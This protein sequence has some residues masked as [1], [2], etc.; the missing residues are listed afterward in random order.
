MSTRE[1]ILA[2][3]A[4]LFAQK[5]AQNTS[6]REIAAAVGVTKTAVLYHFTTKAEILATLLTPMLEDMEATLDAVERAA[7]ERDREWHVAV[8]MLDVYMAHRRV[9]GL[10]VQNLSVLAQAPVY[11]RW[12]AAMFRAN[13]LVTGD[14]STLAERVRATQA[15]ALL[16][17]PVIVIGDAPDEELRHLILDGLRRLLGVSMPDP[18][19]RT[20]PPSGEPAGRRLPRPRVHPRGGRPLSM[21]PEMIA[22]ARR[23][24]ESGAHTMAEIAATLGVSRATLYRHI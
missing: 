7:L 18:P 3:A 8:A 1:R 24:H 16:S 4:D 15:M 23:M 12:M 13:D 20:T 2:A 5:G 21:S 14:A 10:P 17:D 9:L 6:I 19:P 11:E 22:T